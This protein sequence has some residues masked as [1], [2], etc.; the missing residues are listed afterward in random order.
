M[1]EENDPIFQFARNTLLDVM[2]ALHANGIK[3]M[4]VGAVMRLLGVDN[5]TAAQHDHEAIE[6]EENFGELASTLN[7]VERLSPSIPDGTTIH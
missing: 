1:Q 5:E 3:T 6:I 2:T 4:H 7:I